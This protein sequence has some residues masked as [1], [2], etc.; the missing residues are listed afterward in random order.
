MLRS[1][2]HLAY[3]HR[4]LSDSGE[5][6]FACQGLV[7]LTDLNQSGDSFDLLRHVGANQSSDAGHPMWQQWEAALSEL[8][9][10]ADAVLPV[11]TD[12]RAPS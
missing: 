3:R 7:N 2:L 9:T 8:T 6:D 12:G 11:L 1:T 5:R 4:C 10:D